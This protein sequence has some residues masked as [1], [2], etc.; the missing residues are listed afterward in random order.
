MNDDF[1]IAI[2]RKIHQTAGLHAH[3]ITDLLWDGDLTL[4]GECG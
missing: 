3:S 4:D 1:T 2:D